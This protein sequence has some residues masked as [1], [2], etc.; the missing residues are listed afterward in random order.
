MTDIE[1][2]IFADI[3]RF[4]QSHGIP[5]PG[6]TKACDIYWQKIH[7]DAINLIGAKYNNYPLAVELMVAIINY[8][9]EQGHAVNRKQGLE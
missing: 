6:N 4:T 9:E 2:N 1:K 5:P 7:D 3:Y 8:R